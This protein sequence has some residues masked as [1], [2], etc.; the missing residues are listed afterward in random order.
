[1]VQWVQDDI[2]HDRACA[3]LPTVAPLAGPGSVLEQLL[4][5]VLTLNLA[6]LLKDLHLA[7]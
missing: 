4:R 5:D 2:D 1:M 6:Q 3:P 7:P